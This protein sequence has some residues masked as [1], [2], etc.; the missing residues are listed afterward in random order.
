MV[1]NFNNNIETI[2][3]NFNSINEINSSFINIQYYI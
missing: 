1:S 3:G 2:F